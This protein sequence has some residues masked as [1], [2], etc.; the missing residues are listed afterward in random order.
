MRGNANAQL[1]LL[2]LLLAP[3][4]LLRIPAH[5]ALFGIDGPPM[6]PVAERECNMAGSTELRFALAGKNRSKSQS[7][8]NTASS[9]SVEVSS[10]DDVLPVSVPIVGIFGPAES[11][12]CFWCVT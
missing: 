12:V 10:V 4:M 6:Q 5:S 8:N 2:L 3:L 11:G 1:L 9:H 7:R